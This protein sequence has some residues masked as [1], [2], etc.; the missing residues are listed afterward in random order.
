MKEEF[1]KNNQELQIID[2]K[3]TECLHREQEAI[4]ISFYNSSPF[5]MGVVELSER[6]IL[7]ISNNIATA[8]FFDFETTLEAT[9]GKWFSELDIPSEYIQLWLTHYQLSQAQ[10]HPIKF[11]YAH[12]KENVIHWLSVTVSFIGFSINQRPRFSY[13]AED[14]SDRKHT[15]SALYDST[16]RWQFAIE[17]AGGGLWDWNI[18]TNEAF[19]SRQWKAMLG[20]ED[21][22]INNDSNEWDIRLHPE[23]RDRVYAE[24]ERHLR[25]E[26]EQCSNEYRIK[27]K[28]GS[29]KWILGSGK[30]M[31][32]SPD[33]KPLRFVGTNIDISDRKQAELALNYASQQLQERIAELNQR[34]SEMV[35][36]HKIGNFMQACITVA[37]ACNTLSI[38]VQPL[39][40]DCAGGIFIANDSDNKFDLIASWG[41]PLQSETSFHYQDC[42]ALRRGQVHHIAKNQ[43]GLH[44]KHILENDAIIA[45]ICIPMIAQGEALGLFYLNA[46]TPDALSEPKQQLARTLAEQVGMAISNLRLQETLQYQSTRDPLT[47][48]FNRRYLEESLNQ[49]ILRSK[50]QKHQIGVIILDI[51]HFKQFND[52]YGHDAGDYVLQIV[53]NLLKQYVRGSDIPCRW[54]GE[55]ILLVLP[56]SSLEIASK[57]AEEIR[58]AIA[59]IS[60]NYNGQFLGS[61]TASLGVASFPQ[62]GSKGS[63][64]IQAADAAL[65]SAKAAGRN[66]VL[67]AP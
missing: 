50:R 39:F 23:D 65:Y 56:D 64:V 15:E 18:Q 5:M 53:G 67:T 47:G 16:I 43:S 57:R 37:E 59:Q 45:T 42:W 34:H 25:G 60:L 41:E 19:L 54:G 13:L 11:E 48:L 49:E 14:I 20:F 66:Q 10:Q 8:T 21:N 62:H 40:P 12:K 52:T 38:L 3:R 9:T 29:Y 22:E 17:G 33:G 63:A 55:E 31:S 30:V 1:G 26:T 7:L 24:I 28:D 46:K 6:D 36:L 4:L 32:R 44:C 27:C 2:C 61:L 51:D 35:T 58:E